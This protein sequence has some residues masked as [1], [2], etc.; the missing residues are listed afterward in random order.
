MTVI[1]CPG[2]HD[3]QLTQSFLT[4]LGV[5]LPDYHIF[6]TDQYA[7]YS[8]LDVLR[9]LDHKVGSKSGFDL[10]SPTSLLL[11]GFSAGVVGAIAAAWAWQ[12]L[13]GEV[14]ALVA[15]DGWGVPLY[16]DFPIYRLSHDEFT[17]WSSALLGV[18]TTSFYAD[19]PVAHL[20]LWRSPHTAIGY[21]VQ[22]LQCVLGLPKQTPSSPITAA[23]FLQSLLLRY[24]ETSPTT[25]SVPPIIS[26]EKNS[27]SSKIL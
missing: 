1:I 5:F 7:A 3:S 22:P 13:G 9:F 24:G 2:I 11:I 15:L 23:Q 6:P 21:V 12:V 16:G 19:P 4:N 8:G 20:D 14:K 25:P 10:S 18:G 26:D 17:H 27:K